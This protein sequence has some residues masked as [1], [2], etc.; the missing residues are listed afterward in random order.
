MLEFRWF[1]PLVVICFDKE[2]LMSKTVK[3]LGELI[4]YIKG[5]GPVAVAFSGGVDSG[6]VAAAA[7][8]AHGRD[9]IAFTVGSELCTY[10]EAREAGWLAKAVGIRHETIPMTLLSNE[11]VAGNPVDRCYHCKKE[12]FRVIAER[13]ARE[14][15]RT[16]I[17]GT[18]LEDTHT[19]RPGLKALGELGVVSPLLALG[20]T[21]DEVRKAAKDL[22]LPNYAKPSAPCL[23]TRFPYGTHLT[24][25]AIAR[26]RAAEEFIR[27]LGIE[28]LR[29][30][31][32]DG[33]ARIE[34][35]PDMIPKLATKRMSK[36][37][38]AKLLSLGY[39]Y[40]T[41]DMEGYR[42]GS[43]DIGQKR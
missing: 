27:S 32:H 2:G 12:V 42:S 17:D 35:E 34:V 6:L 14:G 33:V 8:R 37:I 38:V 7:F 9:A 39:N 40:V 31:D 25:E 10:E 5:L 20:F 4:E 19:Y 22:G 41:L 36:K 30:R 11:A 23:A 18:N 43:M 13:A 28:V 26:V 3:R 1:N 21:K 29:V 15:I 24:D 16:V